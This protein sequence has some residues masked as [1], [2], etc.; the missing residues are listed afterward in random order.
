MPAIGT[1]DM[2]RDSLMRKSPGSTLGESPNQRQ[3]HTNQVGLL[4]KSSQCNGVSCVGDIAGVRI[5]RQ[6][7]GADTFVPRNQ[8]P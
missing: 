2:K 4:H 8:I 5:R 7:N 3:V 1:S 6:H